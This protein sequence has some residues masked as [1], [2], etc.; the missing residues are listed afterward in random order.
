MSHGA[1]IGLRLR[2]AARARSRQLPRRSTSVDA[3]TMD[4]LENRGRDS[5][6]SEP[7]LLQMIV[8]YGWAR[9]LCGLDGTSEHRARRAP[10]RGHRSRQHHDGKS[11]AKA[12][13]VVRP[14]LSRNIPVINAHHSRWAY[15]GCHSSRQPCG[16]AD[17][18]APDADSQKLIMNLV[19]SERTTGRKPPQAHVGAQEPA[20]R[21]LVRQRQLMRR[22][23]SG[24]FAAVP[25]RL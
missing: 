23:Q 20:A 19:L 17:A 16:R 24:S 7:Q 6:R 4:R 12:E 8:T 9:R 3:A 25:Q 21:Q 15:P 13:N 14:R 5:A 10:R 11:E 22:H 1:I 18:A 2:S